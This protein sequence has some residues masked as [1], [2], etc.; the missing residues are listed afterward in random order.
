MTINWK[1][2][3]KSLKC[4]QVS[5]SDPT[6]IMKNRRINYVYIG[7]LIFQW[8]DLLKGYKKMSHLVAFWGSYCY[9][10]F[11]NIICFKIKAKYHKSWK[12]CHS[13]SSFIATYKTC[14]EENHLSFEFG[15]NEF[16]LCKFSNVHFC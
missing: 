5:S 10:K 7:I 14:H 12:F 4:F 2:M 15:H 13:D 9:L 16:N 1:F 8:K 3:K 6:F 11:Q